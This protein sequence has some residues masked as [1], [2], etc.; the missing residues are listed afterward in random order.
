MPRCTYKYVHTVC[1]DIMMN[2]IKD[3]FSVCVWNTVAC[4]ESIPC[5]MSDSNNVYINFLALVLYS[6]IV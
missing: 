1:M 5:E 6:Q 3:E 4:W 2:R